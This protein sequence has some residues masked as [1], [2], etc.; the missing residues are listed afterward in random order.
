MRRKSDAVRN[1]MTKEGNLWPARGRWK[2]WR[3]CLI[4]IYINRKGD[5]K[6]K[7]ISFTR[8]IVLGKHIYLHTPFLPGGESSTTATPGSPLC[9]CA[10]SPQGGRMT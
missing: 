4:Y 8:E 3:D 7:M 9:P 5:K 10:C 6:M 2:K 1:G